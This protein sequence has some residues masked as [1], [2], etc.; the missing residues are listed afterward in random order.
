MTSL[1]TILPL[2]LCGVS[3]SVYN[4]ESTFLSQL[5]WCDLLLSGCLCIKTHL[6]IELTCVV[7]RSTAALSLRRFVLP[8][9]P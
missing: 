1:F 3:S 7:F 6:F 4:G 8:S 2:F 9:T 5:L